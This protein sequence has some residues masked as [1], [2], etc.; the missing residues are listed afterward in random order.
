MFDGLEN[1]KVE[2]SPENMNALC[3]VSLK[4]TRVPNICTMV[5]L[6][7]QPYS[8]IYLSEL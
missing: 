7:V 4:G 8:V 6:D 2:L 1:N 3:K 5:E